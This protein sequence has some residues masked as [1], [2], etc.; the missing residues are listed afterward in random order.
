[1][2][3][4]F[5]QN[6]SLARKVLALS[7]CGI[8]TLDGLGWITGVSILQT[9]NAPRLTNVLINYGPLNIFCAALL[10]TDW[11]AI[12]R[13]DLIYRGAVVLK[14]IYLLFNLS[15]AVAL[16]TQSTGDEFLR[17]WLFARLV[18]TL[19][20]FGVSLEDFVYWRDEPMVKLPGMR[21]GDDSS[22]SG[23]SAYSEWVNRS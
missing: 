2:I 10:A 19:A 1:M 6:P 22:T 4:A 18:I 8:L 9:T 15:M 13:R 21:D 23:S 16:L 12:H 14:S 7:F 20:W 5:P 17:P 11:S 3:R